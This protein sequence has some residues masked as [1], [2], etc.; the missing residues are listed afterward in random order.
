M[1]EGAPYGRDM[2][3]INGSERDGSLPFCRLPG[4]HAMIR[5]MTGHAWSGW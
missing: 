4:E 3:D 2:H 1:P 5:S